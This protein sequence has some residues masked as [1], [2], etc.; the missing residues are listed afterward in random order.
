ML[1]GRTLSE[2]EYSVHTCPPAE[3]QKHLHASAVQLAVCDARDSLTAALEACRIVRNTV[4]Y[5]F[6][7]V[8]TDRNRAGY[9]Q[10]VKEGADEILPMPMEMDELKTLLQRIRRQQALQQSVAKQAARQD[11]QRA[12]LEAQHL[13]LENILTYANANNLRYSELFMGL[14]TACFTYDNHGRV[15]EWNNACVEA[16][17]IEPGMVVD[18]PFWDVLHSPDQTEEARAM[19]AEV[20]SGSR[21]ENREWHIR[22]ADNTDRYIL[23]SSFPFRASD[24]TIVAAIHAGIDITER[25]KLERQLEEK[26]ETERHLNEKLMATNAML[27]DKEISLSL[28]NQLLEQSAITDHLT[29]LRNVRYFRDQLEREFV[30]AQR[31]NKPFSVVMLDVDMFKQY[32]DTFGHPAGDEVLR[33][34]AAVLSGNIRK[35]DLLAR[36]GGEEFVLLLPMTNTQGAQRLAEKLRRGLEKFDWPHR[37]VTA[38]FGVAAMDVTCDSSAVLLERADR[39]M[40]ESKHAGRNRVTLWQDVNGRQEAPQNG[41]TAA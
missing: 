41:R 26:L 4:E 27:R 40:Y 19:V 36:Y 33:T 20:F 37:T 9:W 32:N 11:L 13:E 29:G 1:I 14:P 21:V 12:D 28:A 31:Y 35:G 6:I 18:R 30:N 8:I 23:C 7:A 3:F 5:T 22:R 39:A 24:G 34:V 17:G 16:Y 10:L 25:R 15:I 2:L 38:S